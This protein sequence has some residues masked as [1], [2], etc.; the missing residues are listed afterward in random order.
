MVPLA[1]LGFWLEGFLGL[2]I[3]IT[4]LNAGAMLALVA[5]APRFIAARRRELLTMIVTPLPAALAGG[6]LAWAASSGLQ[7]PAARLA[8]GFAAAIFGFVVVWELACRLPWPGTHRPLSLLGLLR[9]VRS[10]SAKLAEV[11][12]NTRAAS[13]TDC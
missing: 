6:A 2:V 12:R 7:A 4:V 13:E 9:R 5:L 3:A 11:S 10:P 8:V 1:A